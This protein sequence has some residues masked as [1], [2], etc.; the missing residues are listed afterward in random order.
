MVFDL[1]AARGEYQQ[2]LLRIIP[3]DM[4]NAES[5][6]AWYNSPAQ[7]KHLFYDL[8]GFHP[9]R[10]R[11]TGNLTVGKEAIG[12]SS[13]DQ[14]GMLEKRHPEFTGLFHR[15]DRLG[16]I[17]TALDV[18]QTPLEADGRMKCSYNPGGT[19]SHRLSSSRN[20]W[21]RGT[22]LQNLTKGEEDE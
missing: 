6:T 8:L 20:V 14:T 22:N 1:E 12:S 7:T 3:Q 11:K 4:V 17:D 2:S 18:V 13:K 5:K 21:K 19:E 16:T 9:V 15:L 10:N